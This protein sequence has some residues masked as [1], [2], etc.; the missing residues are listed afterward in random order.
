VFK[1]HDTDVNTV[2]L[3]KTYCHLYPKTSKYMN[4]AIT[5]L[6]IETGFSIAHSNIEYTFVL[7]VR[8]ENLFIPDIKK[9]ACAGS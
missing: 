7:S 9:P 1:R 2:N 8:P 5:G 6:N 3:M 4:M